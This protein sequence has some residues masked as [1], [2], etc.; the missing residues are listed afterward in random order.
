MSAILPYTAV[1]H[2][3]DGPYDIGGAATFYNKYPFDSNDVA[4]RQ[5]LLSAMTGFVKDGEPSTDNGATWPLLNFSGNGCGNATFD[6][7]AENVNAAAFVEGS[8]SEVA[9]RLN[10]WD[11]LSA[12]FDLGIVSDFPNTMGQCVPGCD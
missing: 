11:Q 4:V 9:R 6:Y 3:T 5:T 12:A 2:G 1:A 7:L 10:F 8:G